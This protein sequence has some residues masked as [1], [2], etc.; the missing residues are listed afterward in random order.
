MR[1][2]LNDPFDAVDEMLDGIELALDGRVRRLASGR[3][4]VRTQ[5]HP[6]RRVGIVT[7][8]GSGHEPAFLGYVGSGV[9]DGAAVGNVFASPAANPIVEVG[10]AV[11][12]GEG[13]LFVYGNYEGD[14]MNFGL[15]AEF[16]ADAG[17]PTET[18]LVTDDVA[19]APSPAARRGVAGS[20]VVL[21]AAG[22]RADEGAGLEDVLAA[23][24]AANDRTRTVG[25]GLGP[26]VVPTA[27][28][29]T[30]QIAEGEMDIGMGIHGEAGLRRVPIS[31][32]ED[33]ARELVTMILEDR[34]P[35]EGERLLVLVNTLGATPLMEGYVVLRGVTEAL[36]SA[37]VAVHRSLVGEY[38][39]SLEM[40]GL[41]LTLVSLDDEL[42]RLLDAPSAPLIGPPID[43]RQRCF[44]TQISARTS[45]SSAASSNSARRRWTAWTPRAETAITA[46][47][48]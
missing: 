36:R 32:A 28:L 3:G 10:E 7:G 23:A 9:A 33:L 20:V 25:V 45:R 2:L 11:N 13:V 4:L 5:R 15:G 14:I 44:A 19:S 39:T 42:R 17:I 40:T 26:C 12:A 6:G 38:V 47:R 48:W 21:K 46:P 43:R 31:R 29:A 35:A 16:L 8:G 34:P 18:A 1:K 24:R 22:A 41:S 30:F 27:G 37:G